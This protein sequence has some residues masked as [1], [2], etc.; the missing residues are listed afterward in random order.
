MKPLHYFFLAVA[1]MLAGSL[2][3][4]VAINTTGAGPN[5][6]AMLDIVSTT[7]GILIPRMTQSQRNAISSPATGLLIY[8][9]DNTTGIYYYNGIWIFVN[10]GTVPIIRGGTGA[11]DGSNLLPSP[12]GNNGKYLIVDN[13]TGLPTWTTVTVGG[14][15]GVTASSPLGIN[16][17]SPTIAPNIYLSSTIP[18]NK[19]GTAAT[20]SA[21]ALSNIS[22]TNLTYSGTTVSINGSLNLKVTTSPL[23]SN[24]T[25]DATYNVVLC[26]P[27]GGSFTVTLPDATT[28]PNRV[29]VI[30]SI[31]S[32]TIHIIDAAA[33][34]V[35]NVG[36]YNISS[37]LSSIEVV[38]DGNNWWIIGH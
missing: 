5:G 2:N 12:S 28:C 22:G 13:T 14:V 20:S 8:Q 30:K 1:L 17:S 29:Y 18:I 7:G 35:D 23:N 19:G 31:G 24:T 34:S 25:L 21:T 16:G 3:A 37:S 36:T 15:T 11:T 6:S 26:D 32:G 33:N 10:G 27:S 4:Q 9:T 38:S